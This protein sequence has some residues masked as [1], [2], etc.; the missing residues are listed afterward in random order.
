MLSSREGEGRCGAGA[1]FSRATRGRKKKYKWMIN[2]NCAGSYS[3]RFLRV[4]LDQVLQLAGVGAD[5]I[6]HLRAVLEHG[7]RG[8]LEGV[9]QLRS[10]EEGADKARTARMPTSSEISGWSSVSTL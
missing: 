1:P 6:L 4:R 10:G 5:E 7:K 9:G 3:L 8:H 2:C